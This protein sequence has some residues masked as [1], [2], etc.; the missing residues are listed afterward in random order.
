MDGYNL[1][2]FYTV[3]FDNSTYQSNDFAFQNIDVNV[4]TGEYSNNNNLILVSQF[5]LMIFLIKLTNILVYI[6]F[7]N[8]L[9][10]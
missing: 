3:C 2:V 10:H 7:H 5:S 6:I 9:S 1:V 4:R 8:F